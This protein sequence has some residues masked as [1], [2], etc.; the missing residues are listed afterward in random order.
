MFRYVEYTS[1]EIKA[2]GIKTDFVSFYHFNDPTMLKLLIKIEIN[3]R[4]CFLN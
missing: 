4:L 1:V 3:I 2:E